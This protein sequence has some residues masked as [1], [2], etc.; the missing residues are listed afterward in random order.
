M[1]SYEIAILA[2]RYLAACF[3]HIVMGNEATWY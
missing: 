1:Y 2:W 3:R